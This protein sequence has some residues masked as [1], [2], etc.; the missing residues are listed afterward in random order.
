MRSS[1]TL[2]IQILFTLLALQ[3]SGAPLSGTFTPVGNMAAGRYGHTATLL[4]DGRVL[5]AGGGKGAEIYDGSTGSFTEVGPMRAQRE[6]H[7]ATLLADGKVLI[8]GGRGLDTAELFNPATGTFE[9]TGTMAAD[10][11]GHAAI[12][13]ANGKVLV[14][15]GMRNSPPYPTPVP[16]ELYDPAT[17]EFSPAGSYAPDTVGQ[18]SN[19]P[20]WPKLS[21][22]ADGRVLLAGNNRAQIYDPSTHSFSATGPMASPEYAYGM[23]WHTATALEDGTVLVT[24]GADD[25]SCAGFNSSEIY[26]P[27]SNSFRTAGSMLTGRDIH[28]ATLLRD[29]RVLITG[30]GSGWCGGG[31]LASAELF[32]P[33]TQSYADA[34]NMNVKRTGHT[35]TLLQDGTVLLAGGVNSWPSTPLK[36]AEIYRPALP[37]RADLSF[38]PLPMDPGRL[39]RLLREMELRGLT[40]AAFDDGSSPAFILPAVGTVEGA[41]GMLFRTDVTLSN[42]RSTEQD[43]LLAWLP[44]GNT[45]GPAVA[46]F[47]VQLP[48]LSD[49]IGGTI[50]VPDIADELGVSGLGS[51]VVIA[52]DAQGDVDP[53]ASVDGFARVRSVSSCSLGSVSQS[54]PA[55][56]SQAFGTTRRARALGLRH[57]SAYR[58][59]AGVVN[60][61][62]TTREFTVVVDGQRR[63]TRLT[64][65]AAPFAPVLTAVPDGNYGPVAITIISDGTAPW[66]AFASTVDN[67]SGDSWSAVAMPLADR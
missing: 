45:N 16:A 47:R 65:T 1:I 17:G 36:S 27:N 14:A 34:G 35:A 20:V 26:D 7:S 51:I 21:L 54:L 29:G 60:L 38:E 48:A 55:V 30:G 4:V 61:S 49:D 8:A 62:G 10:T 50:T 9:A 56:R 6:H 28:T 22:L 25:M 41:R 57:E 12:L 15:G 40:S 3:V 46:T 19:I 53:L 37:D 5:I 33:S 64:I 11:L 58:T 42:G 23:F 63:S 31:S 32:D 43:V 13:L 24:G 67:S 2:G 44:Q 52:V 66:A 59:N 18:Y 39:P